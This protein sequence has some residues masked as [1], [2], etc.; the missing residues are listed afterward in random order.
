MMCTRPGWCGWGFE[1]DGPRPC[2]GEPG[3]LRETMASGAHVHVFPAHPG[4]GNEGEG[5]GAVSGVRTSLE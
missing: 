1:A 2:A 4:Y 3:V 5:P